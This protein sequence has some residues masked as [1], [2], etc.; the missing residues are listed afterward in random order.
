MRVGRFTDSLIVCGRTSIVMAYER[1][2]SRVL[3]DDDEDDDVA[4]LFDD[5]FLEHI[6]ALKQ[7]CQMLPGAEV[8]LKSSST[9][10]ASKFGEEE[11]EEE[12]DGEV[13]DDD[14]DDDALLLSIERKFLGKGGLVSGPV[15]SKAVPAKERIT[16][17]ASSE[18][19]ERQGVAKDGGITGT[20]ARRPSVPE[21]DGVS[22]SLRRSA[23]VCENSSDD[24][25]EDLLRSVKESCGALD[26][27]KASKHE[28]TT[29]SN[30]P[31][32]AV[33]DVERE[34]LSGVVVP[35]FRGLD[36]ESARDERC[37]NSTAE[38]D[39]ASVPG[40]EAVSSDNAQAIARS[41]G[42]GWNTAIVDTV[43]ELQNF[44][45]AQLSDDEFDENPLALTIHDTKLGSCGG[46]TKVPENVQAVTDALLKN[47]L[48]QQT[49][50][51]VL[52]KVERKLSENKEMQRRAVSL[53][54]YQKACTRKFCGFTEVVNSSVELIATKP[55]SKKKSGEFKVRGPPENPDVEIY[56]K[57]QSQLPAEFN[58]KKWTKKE[59]QALSKGVRQQL[60]E[61]RLRAMMEGWDSDEEGQDF[62]EQMR[63]IGENEEELK[64]GLPFIDWNEVARI[65]VSGRSAWECKLQWENN[66]NP[67][68][69]SKPWTKAEDKKLLS[70]VQ[71]HDMVEWAAIA[72]EL[73]TQ[74]TPAQCAIRYQRSLNAAILRSA[75]TPEEDEQ[76]QAAVEKFGEKDWQSVAACMEG[77]LGSQCMS[78]WTKV[79][80]PDRH[81][82]GRWLAEEDTR[83]KWAVSVYGPRGW[84][85][86]AAHVP[87]R[88]D[89]Q[90]RERW[91]N[92]LDPSV[93]IDEWSPEEDAKLEELVVKYGR[94]R[95]AAVGA[96][97]GRTDNQCFRHWKLLHPEHKISF[98]KDMAIRRA[99]LANN[100]VGREKERPDLGFQDFLP[101]PVA[102]E[103]EHNHPA[104]PK[105][106]T[107]STE[108]AV[109]KSGKRPS[110]KRKT[111]ELV[112]Q[113]TDN[114]PTETEVQAV[115]V[116]C[117]D[118]SNSMPL[119]S[120]N[121][122]MR[123]QAARPGGNAIKKRKLQVS[124][125]TDENI[126]VEKELQ[127]AEGIAS[128]GN[129]E[130]RVRSLKKSRPKKAPK[131]VELSSKKMKSMELASETNDDLPIQTDLQIIEVASA[132]GSNVAPLNSTKKSKKRRSSNPGERAAKK[133]KTPELVSA[134]T[135]N[136]LIEKD[137][138]SVEVDSSNGNNAAPVNSVEES[139]RIPGSK[140]LCRRKKSPKRRVKT[141]TKTRI[142]EL[143]LVLEEMLPIQNRVPSAGE[144]SGD[145]VS[146]D[147]MVTTVEGAR[148]TSSVN[149]NYAQEPFVRGD[150]GNGGGASDADL[151]EHRTNPILVSNVICSPCNDAV[152]EKRDE[153]DAELIVYT[154]RKNR[155]SSCSRTCSENTGAVELS[156]T[157]TVTSGVGQ[158]GRVHETDTTAGELIQE[159]IL[160]RS[161]KKLTLPDFLYSGSKD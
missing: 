153:E 10:A 65:Y 90:C 73:D 26:L 32:L 19:E 70:I 69:N 126:L 41:E 20:T 30:P 57:L 137:L 87:G 112:S 128:N 103:E 119:N 155:V 76:L 101:P 106:L 50:R 131:P 49:L 160:R 146:N 139:A 47:R 105:S 130:V 25:D 52:Q 39:K 110:K 2:L 55:A 107:T 95:W 151:V 142:P 85:N 16:P 120:S 159:P 13:D 102:G 115:V 91:C 33:G 51:D 40:V 15:R 4:D 42:A 54:E 1:G 37:A 35:T 9:L 93:K 3:D 124:T 145:G 98:K 133:R 84:K 134:I 11:Y 14:D 122:A 81:R 156:A 147:S 109:R 158:D 74:R 6:E 58:V 71:A 44:L 116:D 61:I 59:T 63:T 7:A 154:R 104:S 161:R 127:R 22:Q 38:E 140:L 53:V 75:W 100:F 43:D 8:R 114:F 97:L 28:K 123:R 129:Q 136:L 79:L 31:S 132:D 56:R 111:P 34:V 99:A 48:C 64:K 67:L 121:G 125:S 144:V 108:N 46:K 5:E 94:H 149:G 62:D 18:C 92:V 143:A 12:G 77:R 24:E 150:T 23:P 88:S 157:G 82:R 45:P 80:H 113:S 66:E 135:E 96:E 68:L 89:V 118:G 36:T 117:A 83:L 148:E 86:I 138:Q 17:R 72:E 21:T 152:K 141:S 60:Q 78:R 27:V 29:L